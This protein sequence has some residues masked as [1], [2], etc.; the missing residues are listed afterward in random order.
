MSKIRQRRASVF[1]LAHI[2]TFICTL[3]LSD[4]SQGAE[5]T[6]TFRLSALTTTIG[7][8]AGS[9]RPVLFSFDRNTAS[10]APL[11]V[12]VEED[13]PVGAGE[14]L[15][16][17][18]WQ[19]AMVAALARNDD[20]HGA[21]IIISVP[22]EVDGPSAGGLI[23]LAILSALDGR[24]L[25][26][27]FVFTGTIMP[28]G[29]IGRV[30]GVPAKIRAAAA[31]K[32]KRV[33]L[34]A[35]VRF[36]HDHAKEQQADLF[37]DGS[38][39][40]LKDLAKS[41]QMEFVPVENLEQAYAA[42]HRLPAKPVHRPGRDV[43]DLP[44]AMEAV[45]KKEYRRA[46]DAG[47]KLWNAIPIEEREQIEQEAISK[48]LILLPRV[49][50][51]TALRSGKFL[52]AASYAAQWELVLLARSWNVK[53]VRAIVER[54]PADLFAEIDKLVEQQLREAPA[55][56]AVL[57]DAS[58]RLSLLG[59][60]F[61]CDATET[62]S[63]IGIVD[64][65]EQAA[66]VQ[67][68]GIRNTDLN[69]EEKEKAIVATQLS[70]KGMKLLVARM[71]NT[72][73]NGYVAAAAPM[74]DA[75]PK[76]RPVL[77]QDY[78]PIERMFYSALVASHRAFETQTIEA[79]SQVLKVGREEVLA[80]MLPVDIQLAMYLPAKEEA[81][82]LHASVLNTTGKPNRFLVATAAQQHALCLAMSAS[83]RV[84]WEEMDAALTDDGELEYHRTD[85]LNY[86]IT[87]ARENALVNIAECKRHGVPCIQPIAFV[88][89]G[90]LAR[91]DRQQDKVEVL[92]TYWRAS[93]QAQ[94]LMLLF[95][96]QS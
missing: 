8:K 13:T 56:P 40:D 37:G 42:V 80:R 5:A 77:A 54:K 6:K 74:C 16:S 50:A 67:I 32:A 70:I 4:R 69:A 19:A 7:G 47:D 30:G 23:A 89:A 14:G 36:E 26:N 94:S 21:K 86:L 75:L 52:A 83:I 55:P 64:L 57:A 46:S 71:A 88:E 92:A 45:L 82:R 2:F 68:D 85:L 35:F 49:K 28:D 29:T 51:E 33:L 41:L 31:A 39:V 84:R 25:P 3:V 1:G 34:P 72:A 59:S 90:D 95:G 76:A 62:A 24:E 53:E 18:I 17:S 27:D 73:T 48:Q 91:D 96:K 61:V 15:R 20:L 38:D 65:L 9:V 63:A 10:E 81:V 60:Q 93:L 66:A 43:L 44:E 87:S 58:Q 78:S 12:A 11:T 22:G 79:T